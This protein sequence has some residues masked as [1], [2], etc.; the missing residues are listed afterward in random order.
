MRDSNRYSHWNLTGYTIYQKVGKW[1]V[2]LRYK[3]EVPVPVIDESK[4]VGIDVGVTKPVTLSDGTH[5]AIKGKK[6]KTRYEK[7]TLFLQ[8]KLARQKKGSNR[9][10]RTKNQLAKKHKKVANIR[11]NFGHQVTRKV[12]DKHDVA[13]MEDI[14]LPN[15]TKSAKG[16][17]ENPG[18]N[19]KAK[20][21]LNRVILDAGLGSIRSKL[22]YKVK[23]LVLVNPAYTSQ[24]CFLLWAYRQE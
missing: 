24:G 15:L 9:S 4:E 17:T 18:K 12:A 8:K 23:K 19:V 16:T 6:K 14:T 5:Y 13:C 22:A 1:F 3:G 20:S 11:D 10:K 21:G 7:R 2:S